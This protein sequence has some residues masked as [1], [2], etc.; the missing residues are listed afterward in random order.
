M[1]TG[2]E[3]RRSIVRGF[4]GIQYNQK[5]PGITLVC[6]GRIEHELRDELLHSLG[7]LLDSLE[8]FIPIRPVVSCFHEPDPLRIPAVNQEVSYFPLLEQIGGNIVLGVTNTGFF[9]PA[10]S[11]YIFS[12]GHVDGKAILSALRFRKECATRQL[13][14]E[15]MGK[16]ILKTLAMA[17]TLS[18]CADTGC[19]V[20]YHRWAKDLDRN[21]Y[22][23]EPCRQDL[24]RNLKFFLNVQP[25]K[26]SALIAEGD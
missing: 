19:I 8:E 22:V 9:D 15:R 23:C 21:Q 20:S 14:L 16:Q 4:D 10:K 5:R 26:N 3:T 7:S 24:I 6:F 11:R 2:G 17:C 18:S 13:F 12:Y 1:T 25:D